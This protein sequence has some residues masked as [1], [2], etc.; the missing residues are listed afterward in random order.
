MLT[1]GQIVKEH[2]MLGTDAKILTEVVLVLKDV[3]SIKDCL[4]T[5]RFE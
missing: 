2:V 1:H 4:T 5:S 3:D